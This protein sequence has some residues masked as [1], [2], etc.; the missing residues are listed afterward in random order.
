MGFGRAWSWWC[1]GFF[2]FILNRY[3]I[4]PAFLLHIATLD[5]ANLNIS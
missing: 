4:H 3:I 5:P 1:F 2:C